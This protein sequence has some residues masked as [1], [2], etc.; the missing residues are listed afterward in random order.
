[1]REYLRELEEQIRG[2]GKKQ[3]A[4]D[5]ILSH[6]DSQFSEQ[7]EVADSEIKIALAGF[8]DAKC[9]GRKLRQAQRRWPVRLINGAAGLTTLTI[10]GIFLLTHHLFIQA[11]RFAKYFS[12]SVTANQVR[13]DL[14]Q[15]KF[16]SYDFLR[17]IPGTKDAG[18]YLNQRLRWKDYVPP[19]PLLLDPSWISKLSEFDHWDFHAQGPYQ[20]VLDS[21]SKPTNPY[22][23]Q[24]PELQ[25][26]FPAARDHIQRG[27]KK[28]DPSRALMEVRH[29][30]RLLYTTETLVGSMIGMGLLKLEA[31]AYFLNFARLGKKLPGYQPY[32]QDEVEDMRKTLWATGSF[33]DLTSPETTAQFFLRDS[34]P[35]GSCAALNEAAQASLL[36]RGMIQKKYPFE[37]ETE[38]M[39]STFDRVIAKSKSHC[40]L[41]FARSYLARPEEFVGV[42]LTGAVIPMGGDFIASLFT[43]SIIDHAYGVYYA[44][45]IPYLRQ[46]VGFQIQMIGR[47]NFARIYDQN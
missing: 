39:L 15:K 41:K 19:N 11:D 25:E 9:F 38:P 32:T 37:R 30:A 27:M 13:F 18:I 10:V 35:V 4:R 24:M 40:R 2:T 47:P 42:V 45:N 8:G 7:E 28:S 23:V 29:L 1:M 16:Q 46:A 5:E 43:G 20:S 21:N 3:E 22:L 36:V 6:L 34:W 31:Q 17:E 44:Q 33:V 26:I 14:D 12:E